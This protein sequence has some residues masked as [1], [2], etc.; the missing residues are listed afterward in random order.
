M[1]QGCNVVVWNYRGY[2][3][4]KGSP[5][6]SNVK[7][8]A[9]KILKFLWDTLKISGRIGVYGRSLGG[10]P[11]TYLAKVGSIDLVIADRTFSNLDLIAW[12]KV[13]GRCTSL[14]FKFM[15]LG[16]I[17]NNDEN[18]YSSLTT[19]KVLTCDP[20]D[21]VIDFQSSLMTG[22]ALKAA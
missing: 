9:L 17:A 22:L 11:S 20:A 13:H 7:S 19:N 5:T 14:L 18:Y 4:A 3:N 6:P 15:T 8:D 10:L 1:N 2:G 16:W 21:D 12:W